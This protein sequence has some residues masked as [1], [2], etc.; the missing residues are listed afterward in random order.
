L[1]LCVSALALIIMMLF[2]SVIMS[3]TASDWIVGQ[4]LN[5]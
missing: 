2:V 3:T 5:Q 1:E 4:S